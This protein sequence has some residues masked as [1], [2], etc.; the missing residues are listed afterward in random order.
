MQKEDIIQMLVPFVKVENPGFRQWPFIGKD[1]FR[2]LMKENDE[3]ALNSF[4]L[5]YFLQEEV[6]QA[7][8]ET[9]EKNKRG[10]MSSHAKTATAIAQ[11]VIDGVEVPVPYDGFKADGARFTSMMEYAT[12]VGGRYAESTLKEVIRHIRSTDEGLDRVCRLISPK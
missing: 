12:H 11:A 1:A 10:F 6:E 8:R 9:L 3:V 2:R 7:T 4:I 5:Q